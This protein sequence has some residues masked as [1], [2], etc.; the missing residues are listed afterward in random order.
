MVFLGCGSTYA[1]KSADLIQVW[2]VFMQINELAEATCVFRSIWIFLI[3]NLKVSTTVVGPEFRPETIH[4][5]IL[6]FFVSIPQIT[7]PLLSPHLRFGLRVGR[8]AGPARRGNPSPE[9][10]LSYIFI[11][12]WCQP[13]FL[14]MLLRSIA[15][16]YLP[17]NIEWL[18]KIILFFFV[19]HISFFPSSLGPSPAALIRYQVDSGYGLRSCLF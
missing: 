2:S 17:Y 14:P 7:R 4:R 6:R 5:K 19:K 10:S 11:P 15:P 9:R 8:S 12:L 3:I 16:D 13:C 1:E 18:P